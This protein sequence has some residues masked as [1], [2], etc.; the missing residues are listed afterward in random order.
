MAGRTKGALGKDSIARALVDFANTREHGAPNVLTLKA[1]ELQYRTIHKA[2]NHAELPVMVRR[3]RGIVALGDS[4]CVS[5]LKAQD[6]GARM[7]LQSRLTAL[8]ALLPVIESWSITHG[9][10]D[11]MRGPSTYSPPTKRTPSEWRDTQ[12]FESDLII[13]NASLES[14]P[15]CWKR[16]ATWIPTNAELDALE[17][18]GV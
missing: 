4:A 17:I 2:I 7:A 5:S 15:E 6:F 11:V 18:P 13:R 12:P 3:F 8:G 9:L 1:S 14:L 10:G 16:R